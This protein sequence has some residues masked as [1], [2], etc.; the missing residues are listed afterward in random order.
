MSAP[1][2]NETIAGNVCFGCGL[3]NSAGLGV[4]VFRDPEHPGRLLGRFEARPEQAGFPGITHGGALYTALDC[5]ATWSG[6]LLGGTRALWVLRSAS[7][8]YLRPALAGRPLDLAAEIEKA[9]GPWEPIGVRCEARDAD[10]VL[11]ARGSFDVVPLPPE[12]FLAITGL[13]ELPEGWARW[14]AGED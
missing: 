7:M 4:E 8:R 9:G 5:M 13:S 1:S 12:K 11:L 6:M 14:L 3:G 2:V 10:G